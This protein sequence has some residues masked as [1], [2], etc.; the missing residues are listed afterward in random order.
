MSRLFGTDGVRGIANQELTIELVMRLGRVAGFLATK[1]GRGKVLVGRDTRLSGEMLAAAL[2]AG[3]TSSGADVYDLGVIPTPGVAYLCRSLEADL[4]AVISASHNP[5]DDNGVKFF[6]SDGY[7]LTDVEE[8]RIASYIVDSKGSSIEDTLPHPVAEKIGRVRKIDDAW[9]MYADFVKSTANFS[10]EGYKIAL[11]CANGAAYL[12]APNVLE[13]LGAEVILLNAD[14]N[15]KNINQSCGSTHPDQLKEA[16]IRSGAQVG[17][18]HDGDADRVIFVDE[19]GEIVDGDHLMAIV[20]LDLMERNELPNKGIAATV[21]SNLGLK[22]VLSKN[23]GTVHITD[24]GDRYVLQEMLK[25]GLILGGEQSGH[26]IFLNYNSTGDGLI[27]AIRLLE[28]IVRK[29]KPLS[30]LTA[31]MFTFPQL[32]VNVRVKDKILVMES[33]LVKQAIKKATEELG[34][35]GRIFVRPSGTESLIRV[36]GEARDSGM[37]RKIVNEVA[38]A[39][40]SVDKDN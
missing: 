33:E 28:V 32:L 20:A 5:F 12:A 14:P 2:I 30:E 23:G 36:M 13:S 1:E 39:I 35:E 25:S 7:K 4:G 22:D 40:A 29:R 18:A 9:Q 19:K 11:D 6:G 15:G 16:V 21:Y 38:A 10:L 8:D 27:S 31:Q 24:N 26:I 37:V 17:I 34:K 3:I